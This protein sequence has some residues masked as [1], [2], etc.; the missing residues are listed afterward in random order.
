MTCFWIQVQYYVNIVKRYTKFAYLTSSRASESG[1][2]SVIVRAL[3]TVGPTARWSNIHDCF[4]QDCNTANS[5]MKSK[6]KCFRIEFLKSRRKLKE[7][8]VAMQRP[9]T[10]LNYL[11]R[12]DEDEIE[13]QAIS[14]NKFHHHEL[15]RHSRS[16]N[17]IKS[18]A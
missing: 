2:Y 4:D 5:S 16:R 14:T 11:D 1:L 8:Y 3:R 13:R 15:V 12:R 10:N 9:S 18:P 7:K 6:E 17:A